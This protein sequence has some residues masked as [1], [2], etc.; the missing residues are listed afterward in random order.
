MV[1]GAELLNLHAA[2]TDVHVDESLERYICILITDSR[3]LR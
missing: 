1:D 3:R 2:V